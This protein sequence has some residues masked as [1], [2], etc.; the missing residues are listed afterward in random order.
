MVSLEVVKSQSELLCNCEH[1][2]RFARFL[3]RPDTSFQNGDPN[4]ESIIA[5]R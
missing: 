5:R 1:E 4:G 3:S 2:A